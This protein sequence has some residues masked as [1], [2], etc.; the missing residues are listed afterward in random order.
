M[1]KNE[2]DVLL[3]RRADEAL[4]RAKKALI[5]VG[6]T[7]HE[8][9]TK[10]NKTIAEVSFASG[11]SRRNVA[12]IECGM[13]TGNA[14]DTMAVAHVLGIDYA[15]LLMDA[16]GQPLTEIIECQQDSAEPDY[17]AE[18][19]RNIDIT[20]VLLSPGEPQKCLGS[21][22]IP[23]TVCCCDECDFYLACFEEDADGK[24]VERR[25]K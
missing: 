22:D 20:G 3:Q 4:K 1:A 13:D 24:W 16:I 15:H 25:S 14:A 23:G 2:N 9:R 8:Q 12:K 11:V 17:D 7:L 6:E 10:L 18:Y 19:E 5:Y 21:G